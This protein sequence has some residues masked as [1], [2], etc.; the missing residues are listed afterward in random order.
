MAQDAA[1]RDFVKYSFYKVPPG[2][3]VRRRRYMS[4]AG[5]NHIIVLRSSRCCAF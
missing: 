2:G 3:G 5:Y 1:T 4:G